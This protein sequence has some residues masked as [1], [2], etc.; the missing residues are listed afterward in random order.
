MTIGRV[1]TNAVEL[2]DA[3]GYVVTPGFI[4][5]HTHAENILELPSAR[6]FARMGVT[7]R[8]ATA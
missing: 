8:T 3:N 5:V 7:T 6:N 2:I 1:G 4:D